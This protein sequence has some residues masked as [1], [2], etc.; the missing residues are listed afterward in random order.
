MR[1]HR[2][3]LL[4][5]AFSIFIFDETGR[6]LLQQRALGKYHSA[7]LW[8]NTCCGHPRPG[9]TTGA[10]ATRRL[11]EEMGLA[12]NPIIEV[13][14]FIYREQVSG[15]LIEHEFDHVYVGL[16]HADPV[17]NPEEALSWK[18]VTLADLERDVRLAPQS[19]TVWLR[20]ILQ[21]EGAVGMAAWKAQLG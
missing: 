18:W 15:H 2:E 5:R 12:C 21:Q 9:E 17:A 4:H 14:T 10:A 1:V 20:K 3:G 16:S 6:L 7:G 8:T 11:A 13:L 19:F